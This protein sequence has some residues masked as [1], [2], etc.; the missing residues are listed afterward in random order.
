MHAINRDARVFLIDDKVYPIT[1]FYDIDG[2]ECD[3]DEAYSFVAGEKGR[4]YSDLIC[5]YKTVRS[6]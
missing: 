4:W 6:H 5:N 3:A 2:K 1:N